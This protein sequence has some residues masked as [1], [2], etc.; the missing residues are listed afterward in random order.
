MRKTRLPSVPMENL[1]LHPAVKF[2]Q[3]LKAA[4]QERGIVK[5]L[6]AGE[7]SLSASKYSE[8]E[9]GVI[10]W[11]EAKQEMAITVVLEFSQEQAAEFKQ[12]LIRARKAIALTF[13]M[14]FRPDQLEPV[15]YRHKDCFE[16]PSEI[17]KETIL[18]AVFAPIA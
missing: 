16:R 6:F 5:R 9:A 10:R 2:G 7:I 17:D 8:V 15:R 18:A 3:W 1:A 14:L 13:N 4:R 12:L 11:I